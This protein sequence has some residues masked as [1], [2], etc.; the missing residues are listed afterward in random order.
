MGAFAAKNYVFDIWIMVALGIFTFG[1][2]RNGYPPVPMIL[3]FILAEIIEAN[4]H[5][6]L[7]VGFGSYA[8]FVNRPISLSMVVV[9]L[10]FLAWPWIADLIRRTFTRQ[11][12]ETLDVFT[13]KETNEI[14]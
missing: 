6:A 11:V 12:S 4:F 13:D 1:A 2:Q 3:G 9:T 14:G 8:I 5:R 7:G 10:G